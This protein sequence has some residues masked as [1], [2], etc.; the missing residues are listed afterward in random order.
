MRRLSG[1][2]VVFIMVFT[3]IDVIVDTNGKSE[4]GGKQ[5]LRLFFSSLCYFFLSLRNVNS[6]VLFRKALAD[7][8]L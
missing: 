4:S 7:Y 1:I 2:A 6:G 5:Y 3:A 8:H